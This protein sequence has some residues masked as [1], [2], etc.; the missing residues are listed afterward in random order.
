MRFDS[1]SQTEIF[2]HITK[3]RTPKREKARSNNKVNTHATQRI[4][5]LIERSQQNEINKG[6]KRYFQRLTTFNLK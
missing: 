4:Q 6:L 1:P 5:K 2:L 3:N